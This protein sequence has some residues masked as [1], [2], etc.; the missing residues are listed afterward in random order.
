MFCSS[1]RNALAW[2]ARD[3]NAF[4]E[5][6]HP[7]GTLHN[8]HVMCRVNPEFNASMPD[9][10]KEMEATFSK[11]E[12]MFPIQCDVHPWMKA[13]MAVLPNPY[14]QVTDKDGKFDLKNL[15][16]G[17]YTLVAWQELYGTSDPQTVTI[18][19]KE[20]KAVSF[21]FKAAAAAG[22]SPASLAAR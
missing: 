9:F 3:G 5:L 16:P 19:P 6:W 21:T 14:F 2:A 11:P 20:S 7:D 1:S 8:V 12:P 17:T 22:D 4:L 15:P 18:G 10:R 13:Y